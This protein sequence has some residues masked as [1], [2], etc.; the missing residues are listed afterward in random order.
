MSEIYGAGDWLF[1]GGTKTM[2]GFLVAHFTQRQHLEIACLEF[3]FFSQ[4]CQMALPRWPPKLFLSPVV[5][6]TPPKTFVLWMSFPD[7]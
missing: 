6:G 3:H 7:L 5:P 1:R 2:E 4:P